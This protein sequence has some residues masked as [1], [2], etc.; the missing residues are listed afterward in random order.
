M[1]YRNS[2]KRLPSRRS[3]LTASCCVRYLEQTPPKD[4]S[5]FRTYHYYVKLPVS[6]PAEFAAASLAHYAWSWSG[7]SI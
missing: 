7:Q 6:G 1:C 3:S 2:L 4:C 5:V